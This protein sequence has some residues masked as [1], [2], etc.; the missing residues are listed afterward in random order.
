MICSRIS[1]LV[2]RRMPDLSDRPLRLAKT[3]FD[4]AWE[5]PAACAREMTMKQRKGTIMGCVTAISWG[6]AGRVYYQVRGP[7]SS[8]A[9]AN[10]TKD[11]I[12]GDIDTFVFCEAEYRDGQSLRLE[13]FSYVGAIKLWKV[14]GLI[15]ARGKVSAG[16]YRIERENNYVTITFWTLESEQ[17][18]IVRFYYRENGQEG[19]MDFRPQPW[20]I[21]TV[22]YGGLEATGGRR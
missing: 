3:Q 9:E 2:E 7:E 6:A 20:P 11:A 5:D 17:A 21:T 10:G 12:N 1:N 19:H 14:N 4:D 13:R 15:A 16:R 8:G 22:E 18:D